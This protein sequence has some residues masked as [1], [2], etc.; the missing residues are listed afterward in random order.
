MDLNNILAQLRQFVR[1]QFNI[2]ENDA[3]F[4][5]NVHLFDYGYVDSFGAVT[6]TTYIEAAFGVK[7]ADTDMIAYPLNTIG[8]IATFVVRRR[9]GE[10]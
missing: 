2:T 5:D 6:L 7:V 1:Q 8:E 4:D 9:N 3:D 10:I